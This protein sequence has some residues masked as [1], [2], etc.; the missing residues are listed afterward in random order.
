MEYWNNGN[1]LIVI[2]NCNNHITIQFQNTIFKFVLSFAKVFK[3]LWE[4]YYSGSIF[5]F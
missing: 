2:P 1:K 5:L 4:A 3:T